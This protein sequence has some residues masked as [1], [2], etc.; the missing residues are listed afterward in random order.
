MQVTFVC[1]FSA[2]AAARVAAAS[3]YLRPFGRRARENRSAKNSAFRAACYG[4][5]RRGRAARASPGPGHPNAMAA[6]IAL[7]RPVN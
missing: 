7:T 4:F 1:G 5:F 2:C 6:A 3:T